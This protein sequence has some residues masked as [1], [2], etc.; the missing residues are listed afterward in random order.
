VNRLFLI[1]C[2]AAWCAAI[3]TGCEESQREAPGNER[4]QQGRSAPP[5]DPDVPFS[6]PVEG[7]GNVRLYLNPDDQVITPM[8]V[9]TN[10]WEKTETAWF[11]NSLRYGDVVVDI[12]A[13]V[14]YYTVLA[15]KRVGPTGKVYAFEPDPVA[16]AL[17]KK[18]VALNGL[19]NVVVEPKAVSN[20]PG[21]IRLYLSEE[22]KGDHRIYQPEGEER[23]SIEVEAV[24][25]D[26]YLSDQPAPDF[27][28]VDTQG[29]EV[30]IY[31][32]MTGTLER[33]ESIVMAI[34]YS[35]THLAG[36]GVTGEALLD[37]IERTGFAMFDL[38]GV[39]IKLEPL[40]PISREELVKHFSPERWFFTNL[41]LV[42]G[43]PDLIE[44]IEAQLPPKP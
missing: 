17:L 8:M 34:E 22:N 30:V 29:A 6:L 7:V 25:L 39:G 36:F 19:T 9:E 33:A 37:H 16:F 40:V 14:G 11:V 31:Q 41:F 43:R 38:G 27:I 35:P 13:N 1:F 24:A 26:D 18:N 2:A 4:A 10:A 12:G 32:G 15:G 3:V 44:Q 23:P 42:K 21:S 20:E 5:F 28:K